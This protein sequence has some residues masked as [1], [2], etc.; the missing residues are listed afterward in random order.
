MFKTIDNR[1]K[2]DKVNLKEYRSFSTSKYGLTEL[3][4]EF[5]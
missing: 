1:R 5:S 3:N 4:S 2:R